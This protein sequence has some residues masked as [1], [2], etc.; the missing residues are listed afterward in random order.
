MILFY[1]SYLFLFFVTTSSVCNVYMCMYPLIH[2][3]QNVA[4]FC[5]NVSNKYC[6]MSLSLHRHTHCLSAYILYGLMQRALSSDHLKSSTQVVTS[7]TK[8]KGKVL[9]KLTN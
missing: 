6:T 4:T 8:V 1:Y 3:I 5:D 9:E 2:C 7:C